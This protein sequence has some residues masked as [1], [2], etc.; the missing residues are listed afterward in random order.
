MIQLLRGTKSTLEA[1]QTV[2]SDGQ[3][4]FEKDTGQLK[5]GNGADIFSNLPYVGATDSSDW[6]TGV[7][8]DHTNTW[9]YKDVGNKRI[10]IGRIS[11]RTRLALYSQTFTDDFTIGF[12]P[13]DSTNPVWN[14]TD[15]LAMSSIDFATASVSSNSS[16]V[17]VWVS[18][19]L[20]SGTSIQLKFG[21]AYLTDLADFQQNMPLTINYFCILS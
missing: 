4:I 15:M 19:M 10:M 2:F 14:N 11:I 5:I 20:I 18:S 9:T 17:D 8:S 7:S 12:A 6:V 1:S 21:V 16:Y 13:G 3:P